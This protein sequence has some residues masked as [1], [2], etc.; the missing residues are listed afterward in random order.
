MFFSD[1]CQNHPPSDL[2]QMT[3]S[4]EDSPN[5]PDLLEIDF[6]KG[7]CVCVCLILI[8]TQTSFIARVVLSAVCASV[9]VCIVLIYIP[10]I[11]QYSDMFSIFGF[12]IS[13]P[14]S[15]KCLNKLFY[16]FYCKSKKQNVFFV[17]VG[18]YT[19]FTP[20]KSIT[21]LESVL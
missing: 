2:Y 4:P 14:S 7:V 10:N 20:Y 11:S 15:F 12:L 21:S 16:N 13:A 6:I 9:R 19:S 18:G 8:L 17:M 1:I 5:E 3:K